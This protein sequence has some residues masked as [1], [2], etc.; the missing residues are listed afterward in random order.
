MVDFAECLPYGG[1]DMELGLGSVVRAA[2]LGLLECSYAQSI[3]GGVC[4]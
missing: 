2:S 1:L 4:S 3:P